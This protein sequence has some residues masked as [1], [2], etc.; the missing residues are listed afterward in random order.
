MPRETASELASVVELSVV[1]STFSAS[2]TDC[3]LLVNEIV[4]VVSVSINVVTDTSLPSSVESEFV[5]ACVSAVVF[6][7][8]DSLAVGVRVITKVTTVPS[9]LRLRS[10][11]SSS[12]LA[13]VT[14]HVV[15]APQT[16]ACTRS[17]VS[18]SGALPVVPMSTEIEDVCSM[19]R[20]A[21]RESTPTAKT[22]EAKRLETV[23][24]SVVAAAALS[25]T[26]V[27]AAYESGG[28]SGGGELGGDDGSGGDGGGKGGGGLGSGE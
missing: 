17:I 19:L 9:S 15:S 16:L 25:V 12:V 11:R 4:A 28:K 3:M 27:D 5:R 21:S 1:C 8:S 14:L 10:S 23:S 18:W 22:R 6:T 26:L 13:T 20:V 24:P 2:F 7:P